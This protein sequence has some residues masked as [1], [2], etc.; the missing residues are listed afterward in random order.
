MS[1]LH[2]IE[3]NCYLRNVIKIVFKL[4]TLKKAVFFKEISRIFNRHN[5]YKSVC[6]DL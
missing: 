5:S 3:P 1:L 4:C 6:K 2:T